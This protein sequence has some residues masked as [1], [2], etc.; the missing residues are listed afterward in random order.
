MDMSK[1]LYRSKSD[2]K[3]AGILWG[4]CRVLPHRFHIGESDH[5]AGSLYGL[6][7]RLLHYL[8]FCHSP[9]A[10]NHEIQ[11]DKKG[12]IPLYSMFHGVGRRQLQRWIHRCQR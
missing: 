11:H 5:G 10:L 3:L 9:G 6:G 2:Q 1:K 12:F 7:D 8:H 4:N